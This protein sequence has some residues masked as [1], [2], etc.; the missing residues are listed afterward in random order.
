L[1]LTANQPNILEEN[2]NT[3]SATELF[4]NEVLRPILKKQN[5]LLIIIFKHYVVKQKINFNQYDTKDQLSYIEKTIRNDLKFR[6]LL[7]GTIIGHLS[8]SQFD[9][10]S[11]IDTEL[12][13]RIITMLIQRLKNQLVLNN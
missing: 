10:Y 5:D 6:S 11:K 13:R 9:E 2:T 7:L 12:G 4:Q 8:D 1:S 3:I